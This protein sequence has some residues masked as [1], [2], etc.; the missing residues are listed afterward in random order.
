[1]FDSILMDAV[2]K[3]YKTKT[4]RPIPELSGVDEPNLSDWGIE[5]SSGRILITLYDDNGN[6]VKDI[7]PKYQ[8]GEVVA[9]AQSYSEISARY[10]NLGFRGD[11]FTFGEKENAYFM[12]DAAGWKN[13]MFVKASLM[14]YQITIDNVSYERLQD[15][16]EEDCIAEGIVQTDPTS[17]YIVPLGLDCF[18]KD[19]PL[20]GFKKLIKHLYGG[21]MWDSNPWVWVYEFHVSRTPQDC[22]DN[23]I[24][25]LDGYF[26]LR[27]DNGK[28]YKI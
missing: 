3:G 21:K 6:E 16:S 11:I 10:P 1:M 17:E 9:V 8:L 26:A 4:R 24:P 7:Y 12:K 19:T 15:I 13:K 2:T 20:K 25:L 27:H 14:S 28:E 22:I 23:K 18:Y 5:D